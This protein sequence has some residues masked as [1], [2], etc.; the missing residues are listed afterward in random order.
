[1]V[2]TFPAFLVDMV[3]L[4]LRLL[5]SGRVETDDTYGIMRCIGLPCGR[6]GVHIDLGSYRL[7][8]PQWIM[9]QHQVRYRPTTEE[10]TIETAATAKGGDSNSRTGSPNIP[11]C[12][13]QVGHPDCTDRSI[14]DRGELG[15]NRPS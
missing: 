11:R 9:T 6:V 15:R 10:I 2:T 3:P 7:V 14:D 8:A 5:T 12:L 4:D 1:M 13:S